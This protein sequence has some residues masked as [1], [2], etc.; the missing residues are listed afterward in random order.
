MTDRI[1]PKDTEGIRLAAILVITGLLIQVA[2]LL[3]S[4]PSAFLAFILLGALTTVAGMV[5]TTR[6]LWDTFSKR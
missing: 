3:W 2:S 1:V 5:L 4:G 6:A